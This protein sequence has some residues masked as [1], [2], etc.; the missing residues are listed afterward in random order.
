MVQNRTFSNRDLQTCAA[1][2]GRKKIEI[3]RLKRQRKVLVKHMATERLIDDM[4][5]KD[6]FRIIELLME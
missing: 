4:R 1:V 2:K 3:E 5:E 6:A